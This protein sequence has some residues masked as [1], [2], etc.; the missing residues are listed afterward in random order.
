MNLKIDD[1]YLALTCKQ[2]VQEGGENKRVLVDCMFQLRRITW[3]EVSAQHSNIFSW[4]YRHENK[5]KRITLNCHSVILKTSKKA[6]EMNRQVSEA[7]QQAIQRHQ[8]LRRKNVVCDKVA[9]AV[10]QVLPKLV[11]STDERSNKMLTTIEED[12]Q[13]L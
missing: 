12:E 8:Q 1:G 4:T 9:Q 10:Y 6:R 7:R 3:C 2:V 5:Y 11:N 13:E